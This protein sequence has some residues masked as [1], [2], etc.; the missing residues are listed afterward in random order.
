MIMVDQAPPAPPPSPAEAAANLTAARQVS[1]MAFRKEAERLD[2]L[3][4]QLQ[5]NDRELLASLRRM[6]PG[7]PVDDRMLHGGLSPA[8]ARNQEQGDRLLA[9]GRTLEQV[10]ETL[11]DPNFEPDTRTAAQRDHDREHRVSPTV[12]QRAYVAPIPGAGSV[13]SPADSALDGDARGLAASLSLTPEAGASFMRT[14]YAA[15]AEL[16]QSA[17][18]GMLRQTWD[19]QLAQIFPGDK[20]AA[21]ERQVDAML[22]DLAGNN[23]LIKRLRERGALRNPALFVALRNRALSLAAWRSSRP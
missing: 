23:T 11:G 5:A 6:L 18:P 14:V 7:T 19:A 1:G 22:K 13:L 8:A 3:G 15:G 21:A 2:A 17:D 4:V 9:A 20:L 16:G 10:R 12:D